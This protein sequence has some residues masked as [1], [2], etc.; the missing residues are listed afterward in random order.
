MVG[1][2]GSDYLKQMNGSLSFHKDSVQGTLGVDKRSIKTER[3]NPNAMNGNLLGGNSH[4]KF[5][6]RGKSLELDDDGL[7]YDSA[8]NFGGSLLLSLV[9]PTGGAMVVATETRD[10]LVD[11]KAP[12]HD[13]FVFKPAVAQQMQTDPRKQKPSS[14]YGMGL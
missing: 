8:N 10:T 14:S 11:A 3:N 6:T 13:E 2:L 4:Q 1:F 12:R 9:D 7:Q 5:D